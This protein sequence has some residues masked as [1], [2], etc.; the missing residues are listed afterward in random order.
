MSLKKIFN[1][2]A[3]IGLLSFAV[4]AAAVPLGDWDFCSK[5][6]PCKEGEGDCDFNYECDTNLQCTKDKDVRPEYKYKFDKGV[7]VCEP[8]NNSNTVTSSGSGNNFTN[9][10]TGDNAVGNSFNRLTH[11]GNNFTNNGTGGNAVGNSFN[12]LTH[13]GNNFTN[14]GTGGNYGAA[15]CSKLKPPIEG[16]CNLQVCGPCSEG[17]GWCMNNSECKTGL[18]CDSNGFCVKKPSPTN[19]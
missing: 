9:N 10:G 11:S 6:K 4:H 18:E 16:Y 8:I 12:R 5:E 17:E 15:G 7:D 13:S 1:C 19:Q 3:A 14:N 2:V